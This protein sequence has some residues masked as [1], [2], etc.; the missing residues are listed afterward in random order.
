[1]K[2]FMGSPAALFNCQKGSRSML[3]PSPAPKRERGG[4]VVLPLTHPIGQLPAPLA[5]GP[6]RF[7]IDYAL[8]VCCVMPEARPWP[9]F[10]CGRQ[11][12]LDGGW[13]C[14]DIAM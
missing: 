5:G 7:D 10:G 11:P 2:E 3:N 13:A 1:M 14:S 6:V 4:R 9:I 12:A 8:S